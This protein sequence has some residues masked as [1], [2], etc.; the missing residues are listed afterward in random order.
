MISRIKSDY[1]KQFFKKKK[2]HNKKDT[3]TYTDHD[4]KRFILDTLYREIQ[5]TS[6]LLP[7]S[8]M[9]C[10]KEY[11]NNDLLPDHTL[12]LH[13]HNIN[14]IFAVATTSYSVT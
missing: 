1:Y 11:Y 3:V 5:Q 4:T 2:Q 12:L 13:T 7:L 9:Q 6:E 8:I 14:S 10:H